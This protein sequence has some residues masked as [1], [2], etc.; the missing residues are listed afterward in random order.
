MM[1]MRR[2]LALSCL[3]LPGAFASLI[4][5]ATNADGSTPVYKIASAAIEDRV[6][7][8][9][10]RMTLEEKVSQLYVNPC[11]LLCFIS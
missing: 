5:R 3:L 2:N 1:M 11:S 10:P 7:D 6:K 4:S 8:L 9:L